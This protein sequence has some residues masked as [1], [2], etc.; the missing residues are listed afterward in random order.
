MRYVLGLLILS[1]MMSSL[2]MEKGTHAPIC[3]YCTKGIKLKEVKTVIDARYGEQKYHKECYK[4]KKKIILQLAQGLIG[5][6]PQVG[7]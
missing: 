1:M 4:T 2:A 6:H 5:N 7:T 3:Y